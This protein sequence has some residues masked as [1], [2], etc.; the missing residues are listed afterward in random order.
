MNSFQTIVLSIFGFFIIAGLIV[1]ATVKTKGNTGAVTVTLW[2]S[3]S[4]DLISPIIQDSFDS[5]TLSVIY[6]EI[7]PD[8]LDQELLEALAAGRG[9]DAVI[10]PAELYLRYRDKI[11]VVPFTNYSERLFRDTFIQ[12]A[13]I[14]LD[15]AGVAAL[16]FSVDPLVMYYNRDMLEGAG[17]VSAPKFW[18][19]FL[20]LGGKLTRR[21]Q[22]GNISR[23][24][25]ALG[26]YRNIENAKEIIVALLAQ[27]GNPVTIR[28]EGR[29]FVTLDQNGTSPVLDFYTEFANPLKPSYSWNRSQPNSRSAFLSSMLAVYFGFASELA[30]LRK[31]NPN[32]NFDVALFPHPRT[33]EVGTTYGKLSGMAVLRTSPNPSAA[34]AV[35]STLTSASAGARMNEGSGL[36]PVRRDLLAARPSDAFGG[37]LFDSAIR[38][39]GFLDPNPRESAPVFQ[40]MIESI[41]SGKLK[42]AEALN[43]AQSQLMP[44]I[45]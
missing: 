10:L 33:S 38:S 23:S 25:V 22:I 37:I 4:G 42:S 5:D 30:E 32:L 9:P 7:S 27:G 11:I 29:Y 20:T 2:G 16:P 14:F 15:P 18:D 17:L 39:R 41:T 24:A 45:R 35:T 6:Q 26:E 8:R 19:E 13:E 36:P 21:D 44:L 34:L 1:I 43:V 28:Q 40:N 3:V 31:G 12:G